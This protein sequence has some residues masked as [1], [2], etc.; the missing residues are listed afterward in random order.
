MGAE[1]WIAIGK[2]IGAVLGYGSAGTGWYYF[3]VQVARIAVLAISAKQFAPKADLSATAREKLL[4]VRDP[5]YPQTF[6]YGED[7]VS[8]PLFYG[9]VSGS[10]N[11]VMTLAVE[12]VGHEIDSVQKYRLDDTDIP[13]SDL[14]GAYTGAVNNGK[15]DGVA[16]VNMLL[17]TQTQTCA[18]LLSA[19]SGLFG[20]TTHRALGHAYMVWQ[21][22]LQADNNAFETG[23]PQNLRALIR[24]KKVYDPRLDSTN[25]GSGSHRLADATTW[26]WSSNPALCLAD[27]L[28]DDKFGMQEPDERI[29]WPMVITAADICDESVAIPSSTQNRYTC[30]ATFQ[31]TEARGSVR[32]S[33][34]NA[35]LGRMVFSQGVWKMWAGAA[36]VPDVTLT[37]SNLGGGIQVQTRAGAKETYNRVRGKFIDPTRDYAASTYPEQRSS[38]YEADDG[39]EVNALVVDFLAT[40]NTYEAQ[41][42]AITTLLQSRQGRIVTFQGNLSVFRVQPGTTILLDVSEYG[43]SGEKFFVT[44]WTMNE[45]GIL[46]TMIEEIDS[47]W[48]DPDVGDYSTRSATGVITFGNLGVPAPTSLT[49]TA[50]EGGV[51]VE[52]TNPPQTTFDHIEIWAANENVRGSA[53]LV[54]T[55]Q[56]E[57]FYELSQTI[58]RNRYYWIRAINELGTASAWLPNL[59]TTTAVAYP[60]IQ[61]SSLVPDPFIRQGSA[62]WDLTNA[63]YE[64]GGGL[65]STDAIEL[66]PSS[67]AA[68]FAAFKVRRG[69]NVWDAYAF[70]GMTIEVRLRSKLHTQPG[71]TWSQGIFVR[72]VVT[73]EDGS[74]NTKRYTS[75]DVM[76]YDDSSTTG[77]W[78]DSTHIINIDDE[79]TE[80]PPRFIQLEIFTATNALGPDFRIDVLDA[81]VSPAVFNPSASQAKPVGLVPDPGSVTGKV[82]KETGWGYEYD[83]TPDETSASVTPT[84]YI[85]EPGNVLRYG[86]NTTPGTTDMSAAFQAAV[87]SLSDTLGGVVHVPEGTYLAGDIDIDKSQFSNGGVWFDLHPRAVINVK[88]GS[89]YLFKFIGNSTSDPI[90]NIGVRGGR[91]VGS[92]DGANYGIWLE[93]VAHWHVDN[94][95]IVQF[96]SSTRSTRAGIYCQYAIYGTWIRPQVDNCDFGVNFENDSGNSFRQTAVNIFGGSFKTCYRAM[97]V[98]D[99]AE[100]N[101]YGVAFENS[102]IGVLYD[103]TRTTGTNNVSC[104]LNNCYFERNGRHVKITEHGTAVTRGINISG[105]YF[106]N[107]NTTYIS[108]D[109]FEDSGSGD[110]KLDI[111]GSNHN[112]SWNYWSS[113]ASTAD[114]LIVSGATNN[115]IG[116]QNRTAGGFSISDSGTG[117]YNDTTPLTTGAATITGL[118]RHSADLRVEN[119]IAL[120]GLNN[121]GSAWRDLIQINASDK[122]IVG[123]V[124]TDTTVYSANQPDWYNGSATE[125]ICTSDGDTGGASS[126]G[127][128]NQYVELNIGGTVYKVLHDGTV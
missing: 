64:V 90:T 62:L 26:E 50:I 63:T 12:L 23:A 38:A 56:S 111:D 78:F 103:Y 54:G 66:S 83:I 108:T 121:A 42:K 46:L 45:N 3:A 97:R 14:V 44:E 36:I 2:F 11:E 120:A 55:T 114:I 94:T 99:C 71:P 74:S 7:M 51:K 27:F 30:N 76:A 100:I 18:A 91:I 22:T 80:T 28:R 115:Y 77:V 126:A 116:P 98:D 37:E 124:T 117:T 25:G 39:G 106:E 10:Q 127:A 43:F 60:L 15:Y 17:G 95:S 20:S 123:N 87:N 86:A 109:A 47:A 113:G 6:I 112:I 118:H 29:D 85:K 35:M 33:L 93:N 41:R 32:D 1:T 122:V 75:A 49:A 119:A 61:Q 73:D 92:E 13:L 5:I 67:G 96:A 19:F 72:A 53:A 9:N 58:Q 52:W 107:V 105:C 101:A 81:S 104:N 16:E 110:Y 128:G 125:N 102:S 79:E 68:A 48:D 84:D 59:T 21:F 70:N 89:T 31:S 69:P 88:S 40:N 65:N 82:L 4:T 24:G 57:L 34:L 8:G